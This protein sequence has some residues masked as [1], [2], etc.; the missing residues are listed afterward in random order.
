MSIAASFLGYPMLK[1]I[2]QGQVQSMIELRTVH[3]NVI[4][5]KVDK[6]VGDEIENKSNRAF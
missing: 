5:R 6:D 3:A 1:I 2:W 4:D